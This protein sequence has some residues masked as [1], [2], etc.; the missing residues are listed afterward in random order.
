MYRN[1]QEDEIEQ[2][3]R[4]K[5]GGLPKD[6]P[7][8]IGIVP[9]QQ[10]PFHPRSFED[11]PQQQ[12]QPET[13]MGYSGGEHR[14]DYYEQLREEAE[15]I[16]REN[17]CR[18]YSKRYM[19]MFIILIANV[20]CNLIGL[21]LSRVGANDEQFRKDTFAFT[22]VLAIGSVMCYALFGLVL[23]MLSRFNMD[24]R[25]AGM[26]YIL[27]GICQ[28]VARVIPDNTLSFFITIAQSV[29]AVLYVLKFASAVSSCFDKVALYM[30]SAWE[31]FRKVYMYVYVA[32][33]AATIL[34]F[35]PVLGL[36]MIY[37]LLTLAF[38]AI[39]LEIWQILLLLRS[40]VIMKQYTSVVV[41]KSN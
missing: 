30:S 12:I 34:I 6:E 18:E 33:A 41:A 17:N 38:A 31:T 7:K 26:F 19:Q 35:M 2:F 8:P 32:T 40:S 36:I 3:F 9:D 27:S 5:E 14:R 25:P 20:V 10:T 13:R 24:F 23:V 28:A 21:I 15:H 4:E 29:F 16:E 11:G 37:A 22:I 1:D 39:G